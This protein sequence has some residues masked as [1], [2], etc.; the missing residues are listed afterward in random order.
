MKNN[1]RIIDC[2]GLNCPIP[3]INTKKYFDEIESG[4]GIVVVDN[5]VAKNNIIKFASSNEYSFEVDSKSDEIFEITI[6][7]GNSSQ[8]EVLKASNDQNIDNKPLTILITSDKFGDGSEELGIALMK[9]YLF[10]LSEADII[11]DN[12][13]FLNAGV[14]LVVENSPVLESINKLKS[15]GVN[16]QSCGLCLDFYGLKENLEIGEVT[17]MYAIVEIMNK[18]NTIKL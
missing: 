9:S 10:A 1:I 6:T 16:I 7:K 11:P 8:N 15:R 5:E 18:S 12:L 3:V 13:L 2:K 4:S 17:N 14:K